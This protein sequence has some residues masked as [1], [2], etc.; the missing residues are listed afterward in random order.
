MAPLP[1][2][3][4]AQ[5]TFDVDDAPD[6]TVGAVRFSTDPPAS[7]GSVTG[8]SIPGQIQDGSVLI[9]SRRHRV[10][11]PLIQRGP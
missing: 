10:F 7:F 6:G 1:D 4:V 8:Q 5:I 3:V 11:M 9:E 2:G